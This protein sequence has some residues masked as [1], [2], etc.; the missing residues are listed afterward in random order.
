[1]AAIDEDCMELGTDRSPT[2]V[3]SWGDDRRPPL[4]GVGCGPGKQGPV[5]MYECRHFFKDDC[6]LLP[7]SMGTVD[8]LL[9]NAHEVSSTSSSVPRALKSFESRKQLAF[10][11]ID[12]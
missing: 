9:V 11:V 6:E 5:L 8:E 10:S 1:M 3:A 7:A 12:V 2:G 4:Y